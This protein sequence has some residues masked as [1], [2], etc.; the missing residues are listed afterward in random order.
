[1]KKKKLLSAAIFLLLWAHTSYGAVRFSQNEYDTLI[2]IPDQQ[3]LNIIGVKSNATEQEIKQAHR[4]LA[5]KY[6][7]DRNDGKKQD[8]DKAFKKIQAAYEAIC[9]TK[10]IPTYEET[11]ASTEKLLFFYAIPTL[12]ELKSDQIKSLELKFIDLF[13]QGKYVDEQNKSLLQYYYEY[14]GIV[15]PLT[16]LKTLIKTRGLTAFGEEIIKGNI[17]HIENQQ[18]GTLLYQVLNKG[19]K[20]KKDLYLLFELLHTNGVD[21]NQHPTGKPSPITLFL[22]LS[23][24]DL[25]TVAK[26]EHFARYTAADVLNTSIQAFHQRGL[27]EEGKQYIKSWEFWRE[28]KFMAFAVIAGTV[29]FAIVDYLLELGI[30]QYIKEKIF[31]K[32]AENPYNPRKKRK[33]VRKEEDKK[34]AKTKKDIAKK[35]PVKPEEAS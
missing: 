18:E 32:S 17:N 27:N 29:I 23:L 21:V 31:K 16:D 3:C 30:L 14:S 33:R 1:M 35:L 20:S 25:W 26:M 5:L 10:N 8:A 9:K 11:L 28:V 19:K 12:Q 7:P 34:N 15:F 22:D 13:L 6:H 2:A 4:K 24:D